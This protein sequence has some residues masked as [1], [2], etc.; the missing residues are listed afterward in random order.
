MREGV[1]PVAGS[2][3]LQDSGTAVLLTGAPQAPSV[4]GPGH[5]GVSLLPHSTHPLWLGQ[6]PSERQIK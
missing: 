6:L 3:G 4:E 5:H 1:N 2:P